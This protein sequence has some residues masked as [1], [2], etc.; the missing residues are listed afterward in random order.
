MAPRLVTIAAAGFLAF[1]GIAGAGK[2]APKTQTVSSNSWASLIAE[3]S[4]RFGVPEHWIRAVMRAES[5]GDTSALS[6]KGAMGLMQVMP[7]TYAE[8]RLRHH[9][10]ADPYA[11]RNNILA[12]A[13]YLREMQDRYGQSGFLAAYNAGPGRYEDYLVRGRALP[14]ETRAYVAAIAL[15]I[16]VPSVPLHSASGSLA[17]KLA[18]SSVARNDQG[19]AKAQMKSK[20]S[21]AISQFDDRQSAQSMTLFAM[22][23]SAFE[24]TATAGKTIDMTALEPAPG[25]ALRVASTEAENS[26]IQTSE[27]LRSV[28]LPS[29]DALFSRQSN[30][31]WK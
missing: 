18:I 10:G 7:E 3:A 30:P 4:Q 16:G 1:P 27:T 21:S 15:K 19:Q 11:P 25:H 8:L 26:K 6:P 14:D 29:G 28:L 12:G 9:L 13:A 5:A 22:V 24:P 2:A 20:F 17:S 31:A 23:R